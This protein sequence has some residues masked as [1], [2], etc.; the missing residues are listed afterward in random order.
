MCSKY[1]VMPLYL[2]FL[3]MSDPIRSSH[4]LLI[5]LDDDQNVPKAEGCERIAVSSVELAHELHP[6]QTQSVQEGGQALHHHHDGDSE[7]LPD[8]K[9]EEQGNGAHIA[10]HLQSHRQHHGPQH[11]REL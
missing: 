3:N 1:F 11:L 5:I 9:D 7:E 8:G 10:V 4:V 2:T 6:M